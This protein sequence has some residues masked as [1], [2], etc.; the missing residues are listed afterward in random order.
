[1]TMH[2]AQQI[3]ITMLLYIQSRFVS[4]TSSFIVLAANYFKILW[5]T[6]MKN[7]LTIFLTMPESLIPLLVQIVAQ[8]SVV[9]SFS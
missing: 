1:M 9:F 3:F 6:W 5:W 7:F 8:P 4:T 2:S